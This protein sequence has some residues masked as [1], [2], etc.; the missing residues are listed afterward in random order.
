MTPLFTIHAGEYLVGTHIEKNYPSLNVWI[1]SKDTGIDL[2]IT[3][4]N[5]AKAVSLQVKFS[6]DYPPRKQEQFLH[7]LKTRGWWT[8]KRNKIKDS[9]ADYWVF[10][11]Y[12][13]LNKENQFIIISPSEL[14]KSFNKFKGIGQTLQVYF[15]V[16]DKGKCWET[17]GL[18]KSDQTSVATHIYKNTIRDYTKYLNNWKQIIQKL[19]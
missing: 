19:K 7:T 14:L 3:N 11:T 12:N 16:T 15:W 6:K 17:R 10:I 8:L 1:P 13:S 2:L 5:N 18:K 9:N 4:K